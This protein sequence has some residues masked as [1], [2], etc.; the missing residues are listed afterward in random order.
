MGPGLSVAVVAL[1]PSA[2][3]KAPWPLSPSAGVQLGDC[4][5]QTHCAAALHKPVLP[6]TWSA[7]PGDI[8]KSIGNGT[9][10]NVQD[11]L[12][13]QIAPASSYLATHCDK[14]K[15]CMLQNTAV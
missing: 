9:V 11:M 3:G 6:Q 1:Q 14:H 10:M 13:S 5:N 8:K 7:S 12:H 15:T 2:A 4:P